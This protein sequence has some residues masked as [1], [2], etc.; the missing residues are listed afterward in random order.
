MRVIQCSIF[1]EDRGHELFVRALLARLAAERDIEPSIDIRNASGGAGEAV[2]QF[3]AYQGLFREGRIV[4]AP[5]VLVVVIDG[6]KLGWQ[7][8][9]REVKAVVDDTIFPRVVIG[10]P[11]PY[12]ERWCLLDPRAL[13]HIGAV[14]PRRKGAYKSAA[15]DVYK[16]QLRESLAAGGV[17]VLSTE[18]EVAPDLVEAFDLVAVARADASFRAF[19]QELRIALRHS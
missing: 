3:E 6:N 14:P 1:C 19:V 8:R 15:R 16:N 7:A 18:M 5:D 13:K 9:K 17:P 12:I 10:C 2:G 11:D 4:G